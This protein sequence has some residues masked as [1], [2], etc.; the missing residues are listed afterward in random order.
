LNSSLGQI[1]SV[2]A[3]RT[4]LAMPEIPG[5]SINAP[6]YLK[7]SPPTIEKIEAWQ[8]PLIIPKIK[9][10]KKQDQK[11]APFWRWA[12]IGMAI[13]TKALIIYVE[14][15]LDVKEYFLPYTITQNWLATRRAFTANG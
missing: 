1:N 9:S 14:T 11:P 6:M 8:I 2:N 3:R 15:I 10:T 12:R 13:I 7:G 5:P 4:L